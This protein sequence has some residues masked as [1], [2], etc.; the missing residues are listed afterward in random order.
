MVG[1]V[2]GLSKSYGD[3]IMEVELSS[4]C[5]ETVC[6]SMISIVGKNQQ[7]TNKRQQQTPLL[8]LVYFSPW[9]PQFVFLYNSGLSA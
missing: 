8:S 5:W 1:R 9:L 3:L 4:M 6:H 7:R 2:T